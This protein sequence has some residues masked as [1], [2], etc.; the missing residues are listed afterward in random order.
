MRL[1]L[2][3]QCFIIPNIC[4]GFLKISRRNVQIEKPPGMISW[5]LRSQ[6]YHVLH[7][8]RNI[9]LTMF[10]SFYCF[11]GVPTTVLH[12]ILNTHYYLG[13]RLCR[14]YRTPVRISLLSI[15]MTSESGSQR[16]G[17][18]LGPKVY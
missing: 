17:W 12:S 11:V 7:K 2:L 3:K 18:K 6:G 10:V 8:I 9:L 16:T 14:G 5:L 4:K 1:E 15:I 13:R